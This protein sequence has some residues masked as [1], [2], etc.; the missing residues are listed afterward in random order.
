MHE[1]YDF[2]QLCQYTERNKGLYTA[3][4]DMRRD[5][6][7]G[8]R[9]NPNGNRRGLE[10]P[11]ER[12]YYPWWQPSPWVDIAVM[13]NDAGEA[14][15]DDTSGGA[16]TARCTYYLDQSFNTNQ[17]CYCDVSHSETTP[18]AATTKFNSQKW[19]QRKWY[20]NQ[21]A[22][23]ADGFVWYCV[24]L[25]DVMTG[26]SSPVCVQTQY[27]HVNHLGNTMSATDTSGTPLVEYTNAA[28]KSRVLSSIPQSANPNRFLWQIPSVPSSK[29]KITDVTNNQWSADMEDEYLSC[30]LR[31]RYNISTGDFPVWP[32]E[33]LETDDAFRGKMVTAANNSRFEGDPRT[34]LYQ[35]P[36]VYIGPGGDATTV[37]DAFLS[38]AVNTNQ[39]G[40]T[41]QDR[42]YVFSIK[43][44]PTASSAY[45]SSADAPMVLY[46]T[47]NYDL[48]TRTAI[49]YNLGVRGKRGNIVQTYPSTEYNYVPDELILE[50]HDWVHFQWTGSDYNPRRG[51]NDG[52]GGPPD[53]NL[54]FESS[55]NDNARADRSNVCLVLTESHNQPRDYAGYTYSST[56][57]TDFAT[58]RSSGISAIVTNSWCSDNTSPN[59]V[60]AS[61]CYDMLMRLC[62]L[63]QEDD[64]GALYLR[65]QMDCLTE[66]ELDAITDKNTRE[67]HPLNCAKLNAKPYPYLDGGLVPA[68]KPGIF[69]FFGSRNNNFSNR[70]QAGIMCV[71]GSGT[72]C[73]G[74]YYQAGIRTLQ[75]NSEYG[76]ATT[77]SKSSSY[78]NDE[79]NSGS[80]AN[81]NG[82]ASCI[83]NGKG[84]INGESFAIEQGDNDASGDGDKKP[85]EEF[86]SLFSSS[87][88]VE[89]QVGLAVGLLFVGL[90]A[91][92]WLLHVQS[93]QNGSSWAI[94][95]QGQ[96]VL[97]DQTS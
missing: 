1:S 68:K 45:D 76:A 58:R 8:T 2:Y 89:E 57:T 65:N 27:S 23:E 7:R 77:A 36:Y 48:N 11:E 62:F 6:Q 24:S 82:A 43:P 86:A 74:V 28:D 56:S 37:K 35:D 25:S 84:V 85:C 64:K 72:D 83:S 96:Q 42:S 46:S 47:L 29:A 22:C 66:D 19:Q 10:C 54:Y 61:D 5:D 71:T 13:S 38:L 40:R 80:G 30:V 4:Q 50:Q 67:Q 90:F 18:V 31:I 17:K 33:A 32:D 81:N 93:L 53:P 69:P 21:A 79:Q 34:P 20:N 55:N 26:L 92:W 15:C 52:E 78:C 70:N 51:C 60:S 95:F 49:I 94:H 9:Q 91:S 75:D 97:A 87:S 16:C 88:S 39:Y 3:D 63:D 12:D 41:F 59:Q 73:A 14:A 44:L